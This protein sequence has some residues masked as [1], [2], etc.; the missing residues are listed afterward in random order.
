MRDVHTHRRGILVT[1]LVTY[2]YA[3]VVDLR[4][5]VS[6][7]PLSTAIFEPVI[8]RALALGKAAPPNLG[9]E[10]I[11]VCQNMNLLRIR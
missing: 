7:E 1:R 2:F 3:Y 8:I 11:N 6:E 5:L 4:R 10:D 9:G